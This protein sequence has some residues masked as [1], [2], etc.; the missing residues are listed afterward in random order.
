M[1]S[2]VK[3]KKIVFVT[4]GVFLSGHGVK[5]A[6]GRRRGRMPQPPAVRQAATRAKPARRRPPALFTSWPDIR[7]KI[8]GHYYSS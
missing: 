2:I 7:L 8:F 6:G 5:R 4:K 1:Q 3:L